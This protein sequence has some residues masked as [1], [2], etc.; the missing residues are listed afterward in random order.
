M[1][2]HSHGFCHSGLH[3]GSPSLEGPVREGDGRVGVEGDHRPPV[4]SS[5]FLV[6]LLSYLG[7]SVIVTFVNY[8][9]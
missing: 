7:L 5:E 2:A 8:S 9:V 6:F 3:V 1:K 4:N